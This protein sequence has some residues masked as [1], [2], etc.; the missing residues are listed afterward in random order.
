MLVREFNP[1]TDYLEVKACFEI[2]QDF[3][4]SYDDRLTPG[5]E[6]SEWYLATLREHCEKY[7]GQIFVAEESGKIIGYVCVLSHV[8]CAEPADGLLYEAQV[9]DLVVLNVARGRG[10]GKA[11]LQAGEEYAISKGANWLRV[12][13]FTWNNQAISLYEKLG[14]SHQEIT[15]EKKL[16][17]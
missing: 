4:R 13:V 9:V 16:L 1:E 10:V 7:K 15:L 14:F 11:L 3:S 6:I 8:P 12:S 17:V 2:L 5:K